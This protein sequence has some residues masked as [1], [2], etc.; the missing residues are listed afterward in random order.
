[1]CDSVSHLI[2]KSVV[3]FVLRNVHSQRSSLNI[4]LSGS[5]IEQF[6][7]GTL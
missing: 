4:L 6:D 7:H 5:K 2:V 3:F 1:M